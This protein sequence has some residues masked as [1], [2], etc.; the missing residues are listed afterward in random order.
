MGY[1]IINGCVTS[2]HNSCLK[3]SCSRAVPPYSSHMVVTII[4]HFQNK[5]H[6]ILKVFISC[7]DNVQMLMMVFELAD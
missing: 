3:S 7:C 5:L 2:V 6:M 4:R 1:I